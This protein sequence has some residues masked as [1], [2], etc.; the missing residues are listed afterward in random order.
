MDPRAVAIARALLIPR[1][2]QANVV[3]GGCSGGQG[4]PQIGGG[5]HR[6]R[7]LLVRRDA[8]RV[9]PGDIF[10]GEAVYLYS[11]SCCDRRKRRR[12]RL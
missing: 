12:R 10:E 4:V 3:G 7:G 2:L 9:A 8:V 1:S 5:S 6:L 11:G